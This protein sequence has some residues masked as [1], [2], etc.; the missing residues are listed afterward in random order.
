MPS[1]SQ[2]LLIISQNYTEEGEEEID[3]E[4]PLLEGDPGAPPPPLPV[5]QPPAP[6]A[7]Q[8]NPPNPSIQE[9]LT[10][11]SKIFLNTLIYSNYLTNPTTLHTEKRTIRARCE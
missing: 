9:E 5:N 11:K 10:S 6:P 2:S 7:P 4:I 1:S 3:L 8:P